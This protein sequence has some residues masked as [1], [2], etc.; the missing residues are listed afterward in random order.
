MA[1][2]KAL[3]EAQLLTQDSLAA[4]IGV[5]R[6]TVTAWETGIQ[7]PRLYLPQVKELCRVLRCNIA[8][9]EVECRD[10]ESKE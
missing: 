4:A 9:I 10:A 7:R 6:Q 1:N 5:T 3:R 2:I 8:D